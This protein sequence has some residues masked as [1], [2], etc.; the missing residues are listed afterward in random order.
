MRRRTHQRALGPAA[1]RRLLALC[2]T[3]TLL[4]QSNEH[5][6]P[7]R[8]TGVEEPA[9]AL[10][11][12]GF[13]VSGSESNDA[14]RKATAGSSAP[15]TLFRVGRMPALLKGA[16]LVDYRGCWIADTAGACASSGS[17]SH[18]FASLA[19]L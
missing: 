7:D 11:D 16:P 5:C 12:R 8:P 19:C 2:G 13:N 3:L 15:F 17:F 14:I 9:V 10:R 18:F 1:H 6:H 4:N